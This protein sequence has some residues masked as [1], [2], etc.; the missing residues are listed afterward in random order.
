MR[1]F[2]T[3]LFDI[4]SD[5]VIRALSLKLFFQKR[6]LIQIR[7][8][9]LSQLFHFFQQ[10][11]CARSFLFIHFAERKANVNQNVIAGL[12]F[13]SVF[14]TNLLNDAAKIGAAH[15]D[16][17]RIIRDLDQF[18]WNRQTHGF[19]DDAPSCARAPAGRLMTNDEYGVGRG[20]G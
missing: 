14:E 20:G 12:N 7:S 17:V 16:A 18:T 11:V 4:V 13:G 2:P 15:P 5:F 9:E 8:L 19:N 3:L 6:I 1:V 10:L